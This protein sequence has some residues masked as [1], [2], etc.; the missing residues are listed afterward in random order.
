M[1]ADSIMNFG[2]PQLVSLS[3]SEVE[4]SRGKRCKPVECVW[5]PAVDATEPAGTV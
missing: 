4:H 1:P 2:L 3:N 5:Y